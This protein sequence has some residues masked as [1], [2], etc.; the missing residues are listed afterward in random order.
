[1]LYFDGHAASFDRNVGATETRWITST[2]AVS[3]ILRVVRS[4]ATTPDEL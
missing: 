2:G 4:G 1:M 3:K